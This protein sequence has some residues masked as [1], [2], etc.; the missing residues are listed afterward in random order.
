MKLRKT[1]SILN[2]LLA[3]ILQE[4]EFELDRSSIPTLSLTSEFADG[5][6]A[7]LLGKLLSKLD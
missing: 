4:S 3:L 7:E 2:S 6:A 1:R 5:E